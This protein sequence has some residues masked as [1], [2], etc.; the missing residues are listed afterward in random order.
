VNFPIV[1]NVDT[2]SLPADCFSPATASQTPAVDEP[3]EGKP[4]RKKKKRKKR[5][6]AAK[7]RKKLSGS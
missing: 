1:L 6:K 5:K 2:S 4:K 3:A 7:K